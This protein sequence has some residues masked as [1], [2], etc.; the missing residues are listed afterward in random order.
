MF[1][2]EPF[3]E[4]EWR[5]RGPGPSPSFF[6]VSDSSKNSQT[7]AQKSSQYIANPPYTTI[8]APPSSAAEWKERST[9]QL[10]RGPRPAFRGLAGST[11][12]DRDVRSKNAT[13]L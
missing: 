8:L 10:G 6:Q 12:H 2:V 13:S 1:E 4:A 9:G 7:S 5:Q 11:R 3:V